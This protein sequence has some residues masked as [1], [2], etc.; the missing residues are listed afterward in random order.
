MS[1]KQQSHKLKLTHTLAHIEQMSKVS[2]T[3]EG[4][5]FKIQ[6]L[7]Q[8]LSRNFTDVTIG[9]I[10]TEMQFVPVDGSDAFEI[11]P[12][13]GSFTTLPAENH[14]Q[15]D[16]RVLTKL[17]KAFSGKN[18]HCEVNTKGKF[19]EV[20]A[21]PLVGPNNEVDEILCVTQNLTDRKRMEEGLLKALERE[22]ELGD[23]ISRFVTMA[24]HEFRTP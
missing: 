6:R 19:Y 23:L 7:L 17:K 13:L 2:R 24:S 1:V 11:E 10:N 3:T 20:T 21:I 12:C 5:L 8:V 14:P 16:K 9:I 18:V 4:R 22:K 15:L